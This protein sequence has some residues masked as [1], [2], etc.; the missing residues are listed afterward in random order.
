[1]AS[2]ATLANAPTSITT[3]ILFTIDFITAL[4]GYVSVLLSHRT[5]HHSPF[6]YDKE[7]E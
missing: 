4:L 6:P 3:N 5:K 7:I 2:A 1:L